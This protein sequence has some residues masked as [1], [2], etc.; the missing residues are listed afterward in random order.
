MHRVYEQ[1]LAL[2][3]AFRRLGFLPEE[4][5][6]SYNKGTPFVLVRAEGKEYAVKVEA[7]VPDTEQ[8]YIDDWQAAV[9]TWNSS[10]PET[11]RQRIFHTHITEAGISLPLL[12][13]LLAAGFE[14]GTIEEK[15][16]K[17]IR[18]HEAN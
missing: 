12:T 3:E 2:Y 13:G 9:V 15:Q 18:K 5:Y 6:F 10:M 14:L 17:E 1:Q 7:P 16:A 4:I 11:E 8:Q